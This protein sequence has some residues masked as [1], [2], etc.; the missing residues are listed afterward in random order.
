MNHQAFPPRQP[1]SPLAALVLLLTAA[2]A[3]PGCTETTP[4]ARGTATVTFSIALDEVVADSL[5]SPL[6]GRRSALSVARLDFSPA[7]VTTLRIDVKETG[8]GA[9]VYLDFDLTQGAGGWTGTLPFLPKGKTLTF[10]ARAYDVS[11]TLL[12]GGSTDQALVSDAESV[13]I[14]LAPT[15]DGATITL[16]RIKKIVVPY[17]FALSQ[18]GNIS[19]SIEGNASE[20]L[21]YTI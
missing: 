6:P 21:R 14:T 5:A 15:N 16:P 9:P 10:S 20:T 12:F 17:E 8:S 4:E 18:S 1:W 13:V 7:D 19:F 2:L 11:N 3:G